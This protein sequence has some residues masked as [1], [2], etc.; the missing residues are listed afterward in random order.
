MEYP[1]RL[2]VPEQAL[3]DL[4]QSVVNFLAEVIDVLGQNV[5][6]APSYALAH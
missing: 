3:E 6:A 5:L 2:L 4:L 1:R